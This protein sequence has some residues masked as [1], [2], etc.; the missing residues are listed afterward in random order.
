MYKLA[1]LLAC[2][3]GCSGRATTSSVGE[4][5]GLARVPS[6]AELARLLLAFNPATAFVGGQG[7]PGKQLLKPHNRL[8]SAHMQAKLG[9]TVQSLLDANKGAV[10]ALA[11]VPD[12]D[13][14]DDITRLR[15]VLQF[16]QKAEAAQALKETIAWR[17]GEGK[18]IVDTAAA[19]VEKA[20]AGGGW[21]NEPVL[22]AAPNSALIGEYIT[23]KNVLTISTDDGDLV[24]V[25]RSSGIK[26]TEMMKKVSV[27]QLC[28]FLLYA[29][30][31]HSLIADMRSKK[32]G[33][34]CGVLFA[35]DITG[36]RAPP[37]SK[38]QKALTDSAK[39]YEKLYPALAGPTLILNL[40]FVLQ[41]FVGLFK[42]L[43]PKSVRERLKFERAP[44]LGKLGDLTPLVKDAST[45]KSFLTE[46]KG[47]VS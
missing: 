37:D 19:A 47:L 10:D 35:N 16:P 1:I 14:L 26:D 13:K 12:A 39:Q 36:I 31:V 6:K 40:P 43:F 41:V 29:K 44:V 28:D 25:I 33:R 45:K 2:L 5:D 15:Y 11:S 27:K 20:M 42:P 32:T 38:F 9:T 17:K 18:E 7:Q 24:Y 21:D 22:A 8:G 4:A 30:E 34:L 23:P 3:A 46:M